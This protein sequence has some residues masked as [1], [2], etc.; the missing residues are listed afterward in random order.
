MDQA[1]SLHVDNILWCTKKLSG[2]FDMPSDRIALDW[3]GECACRA[4]IRALGHPWGIT[5][6]TKS[7]AV[8]CSST[9][10]RC[11]GKTPCCL[12]IAK[13]GRQ[14]IDLTFHLPPLVHYRGLTP[15]IDPHPGRS[16]LSRGPMV[17]TE[18]FTPYQEHA[19][20]LDE[21]QTPRLHRAPEATSSVALHHSKPPPHSI[22]RPNCSS[23]SNCST[24]LNR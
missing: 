21:H 8:P 4:D 5:V 20:S 15:L 1:H 3:G 12:L 10:N 11:Y 2:E 23:S 19:K 13:E 22:H 18:T 24:F 9:S 17:A 14:L 6:P 16:F 7:G